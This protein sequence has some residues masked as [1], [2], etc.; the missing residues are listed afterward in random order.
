VGEGNPE[1]IPEAKGGKSNHNT[2]CLHAGD[3][4][5]DATKIAAETSLGNSET[6]RL[7]GS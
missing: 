5:A 6:K 2:E 1:T 7:S 3:D 4:V